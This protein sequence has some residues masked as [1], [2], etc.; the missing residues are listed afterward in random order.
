[1]S[2]HGELND[3]QLLGLIQMF[4]AKEVDSVDSVVSRVSS[5]FLCRLESHLFRLHLDTP[6]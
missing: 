3:E 6:Y 5:I 1:M 4:W 2:E